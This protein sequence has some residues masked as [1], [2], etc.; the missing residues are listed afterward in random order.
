MVHSTSSSMSTTSFFR[1]F[2]AKNR[3]LFLSSAK[4]TCKHSKNKW[5]KLRSQQ[6]T[7]FACKSSYSSLIQTSSC[8]GPCQSCLSPTSCAGWSHR[9]CTWAGGLSWEQRT[10]APP[11]SAPLSST[12]WPHLVHPMKRP[13]TLQEQAGQAAGNK[14]IIWQ[15]IHQKKWDTWVETSVL[16]YLCLQV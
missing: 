8:A 13:V 5:F 1:A 6:Q 4:N 9:R 3:P 16:L 7:M 2:T 15:N 11:L 10:E 12:C 14:C